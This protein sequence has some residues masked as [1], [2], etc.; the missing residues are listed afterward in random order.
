MFGKKAS[1]RMP[2]KK[3]WDYAIEM[4]K[5]FML[6]KGYVYPLLR[7]KREDIYKFI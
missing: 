4:K 3:I 6:R 7:E 1:E 5:E 2:V